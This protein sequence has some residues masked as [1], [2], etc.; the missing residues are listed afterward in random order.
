MALKKYLNQKI[1]YLLKNRLEGYPQFRIAITYRCNNSCVY[2]SVSREDRETGSDIKLEDFR[3]VLLWLKKQNIRKIILTGGEPFIHKD[4]KGILA[5]CD[6][7][8][9]NTH[10]LT[11]GLSITPELKA[12]IKNKNFLLVLNINLDSSY[13]MVRGNMLGI[14]EKIIMLRYNLRKEPI[15]YALLFDMA[16]E[17]SVS[18]RFGFTVPSLDF[19][20]EHYSFAD[21]AAYKHQIID[22][23]RLARLNSVKAHFS[24][25]LPRCL[26]TEKEWGYLI[27]FGGA[28]SKCLLGCSGNYTSRAVVNPDLSVYVCYAAL[29]KAPALF[30]FKDINALGRYFKDK[31]D[32]LREKPLKGECYSC[33]Y[34]KELSCQG[35]CLVYKYDSA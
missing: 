4:I 34:Y 5:L 31:V 6:K 11:N 7:L 23:V 20:N 10:I 33:R 15:D 9:F 19:K 13:H 14:E 17:Y 30:N 28:K 1:F 24:R 35:G 21:M 25:P 26:F 32:I 22:F 18:V 16:R 2:C 12:Y 29:S 3:K 27:S 8:K